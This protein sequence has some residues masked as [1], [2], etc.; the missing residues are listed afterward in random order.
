MKICICNVK[1]GQLYTYVCLGWN[2]PVQF[3]AT[4]TKQTKKSELLSVK[5]D[6]KAK[7]DMRHLITHM[8][9]YLQEDILK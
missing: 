7:P 2:C 5:P 3:Y 8:I 6:T 4:E 9:D 1:S